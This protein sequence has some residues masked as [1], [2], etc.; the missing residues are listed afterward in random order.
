MIQFLRSSILHYFPTTLFQNVYKAKEDTE[1][2]TRM[3]CGPNRPFE[4]Q[5]FDNADNEVSIFIKHF[6][7]R[8]NQVYASDIFFKIQVMH[9]KYF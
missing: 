3:V 9:L 7:T 2:C 6:T 4:M 5:I 8:S 1:C